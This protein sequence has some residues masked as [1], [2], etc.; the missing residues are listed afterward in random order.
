MH[1]APLSTQCRESE[2]ETRSWPL[3][4]ACTWPKATLTSQ[5]RQLSCKTPAEGRV[6]VTVL[7]LTV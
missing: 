5:P 2:S 3:V 6:V 1:M 4:Y 7:S